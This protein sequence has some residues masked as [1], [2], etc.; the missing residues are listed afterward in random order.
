MNKRNIHV[1]LKKI[2]GQIKGIE[3][4]I[5]NDACCRDVLIQIAAVRSAVNRVGGM[6]LENYAKNCFNKE[7]SNEEDNKNI[8]DIISVLNMYIK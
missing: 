7:N 2:E 4:M 8:E 1:R 5:D 6:I 3:K